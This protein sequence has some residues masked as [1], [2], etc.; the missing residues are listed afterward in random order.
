M[1]ER[2]LATGVETDPKLRI[3]R[4]EP[5]AGPVAGGTKL[6]VHGRGYRDFG[7]LMRCNIGGTKVAA[8]LTAPPGEWLNP[9]NWTMI[10]CEVPD[11][12]GELNKDV[13]VEVSLTGD[14]FSADGVQFSYYRHPVIEA[15]SPLAGSITC[16]T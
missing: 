5:P 10:A 8:S 11:S 1:R 9:L 3:S 6:V 4:I 13:T 2:F 16:G 12:G 7:S 14:A 15:V